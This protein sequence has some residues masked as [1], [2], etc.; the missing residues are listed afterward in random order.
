VYIGPVYNYDIHSAFPSVMPELPCLAY[1]MWRKVEGLSK[2]P[3]SIVHVKWSFD[4]HLSYFPFFYRDSR[5]SIYFPPE[6]EGWYYRPEVDTAIR[7][8]E[9]GDL[10][11]KEYD[12]K[13]ELLESWEFQPYF[14][15]KPFAYIHDLYQKRREWKESGKPA[16]KVLKFTITSIYGKL[17]QSLGWSYNAYGDLVKPSYHNIFYAGYITSAIRARMFDALMQAQDDNIMVTTDGIY[18]TK[19]LD[20]PR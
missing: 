18:S 14:D 13:M 20:L 5:G 3:Y 2:K 17:C 9:N 19:P 6:G 11:T 10:S 4:W 12:G 16:E 8:Y 1:G 15:T 7:A